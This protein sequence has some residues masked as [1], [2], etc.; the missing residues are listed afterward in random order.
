MQKTRSDQ[1]P[2][3]A[4]RP[5]S[6]TGQ[7]LFSL[8][9]FALVLFLF[10]SIPFQTSFFDNVPWYKQPRIWPGIAIVGML[11]A[12]IGH[13]FTLRKFSEPPETLPFSKDL[14]LTAKALEISLWFILYIFAVGALGYLPS[15][16]AFALFMCWRMEYKSWRF[17]LYALLLAIAIVAIFKGILQV[18]IPGGDLYDFLP[19]DLQRFAK[20]YL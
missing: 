18:R 1:R 9:A 2:N 13:F 14:Q 11:I 3:P 5:A 10:A 19:T 17:Y 15:S 4:T 7:W 16:I 8:C 20:T 12:G 6:A